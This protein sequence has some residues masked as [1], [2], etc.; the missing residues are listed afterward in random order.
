MS[1]VSRIESDVFEEIT[2]YVFD[3]TINVAEN[4]PGD[5][6][7]NSCEIQKIVFEKEFFKNYVFVSL[8]ESLRVLLPVF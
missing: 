4:A 1:E 3:A 6:T 7:L 5:W 2:S 8:D